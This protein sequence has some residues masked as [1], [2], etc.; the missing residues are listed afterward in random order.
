M[1]TKGID[2]SHSTSI[3]CK[4]YELFFCFALSHCLQYKLCSIECSCQKED[5]QNSCN[6]FQFVGDK[7][8][9]E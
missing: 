2:W 6:I 5:Q 7:R 9:K 1:K 4:L 3:N 8:F